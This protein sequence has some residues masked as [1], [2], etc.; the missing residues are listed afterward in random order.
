MTSP[1][2]LWQT[3]SIGCLPPVWDCCFSTRGNRRRPQSSYRGTGWQ[4]VKVPHK[5]ATIFSPVVVLVRLCV[6]LVVL[7][8]PDLS[9]WTRLGHQL[10]QPWRRR[11]RCLPRCRIGGAGA[12]DD[13][14]AVG[15]RQRKMTRVSLRRMRALEL[16]AISRNLAPSKQATHDA[17]P[18][19][20]RALTL[21]RKRMARAG[22]N[23]TEP[24]RQYPAGLL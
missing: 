17:I 21:T 22:I 4:L 19:L 20:L 10:P 7:V 12:P 1:P 8:A 2:L 24:G 14:D 3:K 9:A 13:N 5:L 23:E 6:D 11:L 18:R 15:R 16:A